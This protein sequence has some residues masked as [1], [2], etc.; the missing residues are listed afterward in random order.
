MGGRC[1]LYCIL[2]LRK[3]SYRGGSL[4]SPR[5]P[6]LYLAILLLFVFDTFVAL[7]NTLRMPLG[8]LPMVIGGLVECKVALAR[9]QRFLLAE[10]MD[11]NAVERSNTGDGTT[12]L[13]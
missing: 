13:N 11:E 5:Y 3:D 7:F 9:V 12:L 10:E 6:E 8:F 2:S 4:H 1:N